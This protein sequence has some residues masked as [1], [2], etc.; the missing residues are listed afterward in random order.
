MKSRKLQRY[1]FLVVFSAILLAA[2]LYYLYFLKE[3]P[4]IMEGTMV[5]KATEYVTSLNI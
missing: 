2:I 1:I 4:Q 3:A 5:Q